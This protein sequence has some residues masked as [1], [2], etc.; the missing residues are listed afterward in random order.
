MKPGVKDSKLLARY[1]CYSP[2]GSS[3]TPRKRRFACL[4][5]ASCKCKLSVRVLVEPPSF[6]R[7]HLSCKL[8]IT[9]RVSDSPATIRINESQ[10]QGAKRQNPARARPGRSARAH[11]APSSPR[12]CVRVRAPSFPPPPSFLLPLRSPRSRQHRSKSMF[13][14]APASSPPPPPRPLPPPP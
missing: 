7:K 11:L 3:A 5:V 14:S 13:C 1:N 6:A 8:I 2:C 12:F 4:T 9:N 10:S